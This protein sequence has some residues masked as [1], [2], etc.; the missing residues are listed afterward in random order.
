[1]KTMTCILVTWYC[2]WQPKS[3]RKKEKSFKTMRF[4]YDNPIE[5][6]SIISFYKDKHSWIYFLASHT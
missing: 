6:S 5:V 1:M 4:S 3:D 2:L